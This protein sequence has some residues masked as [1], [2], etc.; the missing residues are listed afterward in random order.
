MKRLE[1]TVKQ[2]LNEN[3]NKPSPLAEIYK[4]SAERVKFLDPAAQTADTIAAKY[5]NM[6]K[7]KSKDT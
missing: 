2:V 3:A 7:K 4:K 5:G 6:F 1:D